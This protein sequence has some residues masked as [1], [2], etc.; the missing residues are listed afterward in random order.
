MSSLPAQ[1]QPNQT[2]F[3][4]RL[5]LR[6]GS[7]R[8]LSLSVLLSLGT[9]KQQ[10]HRLDSE[11][12]RIS[13]GKR[14]WRLAMPCDS[15]ETVDGMAESR[16]GGMDGP[17][18]PMSPRERHTCGEAVSVMRGPAW[19]SC[20]AGRHHE[21]LQA[22]SPMPTTRGPA[23]GWADG[24]NAALRQKPPA[25]HHG[26]S[27]GPPPTKPHRIANCVPAYLL[28]RASTLRNSDVPVLSHPCPAL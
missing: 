19:T 6:Q 7:Q 9:F 4:R 21:L 16:A 23:G 11:V 3:R 8:S 2:C 1:A 24:L 15:T 22:P 14:Q 10:D 12:Y 17:A 5:L 20:A 13:T 25:W 26:W 28:V 18:T 27:V